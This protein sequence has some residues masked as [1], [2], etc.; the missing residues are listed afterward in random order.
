MNAPAPSIWTRIFESRALRAAWGIATLALLL[1][2]VWLSVSQPKTVNEE[3]ADIRSQLEQLQEELALP[4][5][6]ISPRAEAMVL[7]QATPPEPDSN[8]VTR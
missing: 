5:L 6:D 8:E 3:I 7:D 4:D 2:N 1:A